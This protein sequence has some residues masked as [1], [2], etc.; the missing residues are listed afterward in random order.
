MVVMRHAAG[1]QM[2]EDTMR[3]A[4]AIFRECYI[5]PKGESVVVCA[6]LGECGYAGL[7]VGEPAVCHLF[8]LKT[9]REKLRFFD[10]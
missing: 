1:D 3:H 9:Q 2:G 6:V 10:E 5:P 4:T 8:R 7:P